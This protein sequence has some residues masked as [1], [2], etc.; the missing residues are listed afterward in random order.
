MEKQPSDLN[1]EL[2][3][4]ISILAGIVDLELAESEKITKIQILCDQMELNIKG[5]CGTRYPSHIDGSNKHL[6]E[7]SDCI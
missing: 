1:V 7:K 6:L 3:S 2:L 4:C 5:K